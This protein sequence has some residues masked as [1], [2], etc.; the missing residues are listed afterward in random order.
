MADC[1]DKV[2]FEGWS[3]N[4][5]FMRGGGASRIQLGDIGHERTELAKRRGADFML[6]A[7][8]G[9]KLPFVDAG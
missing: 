3:E 5:G 6:T 2:F 1:V 7:V 8:V 9:T 4:L